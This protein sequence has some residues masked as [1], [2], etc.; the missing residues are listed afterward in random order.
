MSWVICISYWCRKAHELLI[1][2]LVA[3]GL[4]AGYGSDN[5][6]APTPVSKIRFSKEVRYN[7]PVEDPVTAWLIIACSLAIFWVVWRWGIPNPCHHSMGACTK[8]CG[9]LRQN[10]IDLR[11]WVI[12]G[13]IIF[14]HATRV[15]EVVCNGYPRV[16]HKV[17]VRAIHVSGPPNLLVAICATHSEE[18]LVSR[19]TCASI[20]PSGAISTPR[21][22]LAWLNSSRVS[23]W[24]VWSISRTKS[25]TVWY[26]QFP[27][28]HLNEIRVQDV[29]AGTIAPLE[30]CSPPSQWSSDHS[31]PKVIC[32]QVSSLFLAVWMVSVSSAKEKPLSRICLLDWAVYKKLP[33]AVSH[34]TS[35]LD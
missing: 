33:K 7:R 3:K 35:K 6:Y 25:D 26:L 17:D 1:N 13:A 9:K 21:E 29:L 27:F 19:E 22:V 5:T 32:C 30:A 20:F 14:S 11:P 12:A 23:L 8:A 34:N 24:Q 31:S 18:A 28:F 10:P 2:E 4:S 16:F 15:M